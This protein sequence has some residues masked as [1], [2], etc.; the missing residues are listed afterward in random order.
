MKHKK[1]FLLLIIPIA[2][3]FLVHGSSFKFSTYE[4]ELEK[5]GYTITVDSDSFVATKEDDNSAFMLYETADSQIVQYE[6]EE[7]LYTFDVIDNQLK[8]TKMASQPYGDGLCPSVQ[9]CE[10][11]YSFQ[12]NYYKLISRLELIDISTRLL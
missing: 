9:I 6:N 3:I 12:I 11:E 2:L 10:E 4:K 7:V 1:Y 8:V 5:E